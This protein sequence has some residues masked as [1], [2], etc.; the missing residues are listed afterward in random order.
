M[1]ALLE[2]Q[3]LRLTAAGRAIVDGV[4]FQV[5]PGESVAITGPSGAGKTTLAL[6]VLG[7]LR[8]GVTHDGGQVLV[9]GRPTLPQPPP[10]LRGGLVGYVG[11]DPGNSLNPYARVATTLLRVTAR[12]VPRP[13]RSALVSE[14]LA[15][16]G[17][18]TELA[19]RYPHQLS[20]GQQ[21]RVVI[22]AALARNPRLLV[23]D[24][25]TTAL[26]LVAKAEVVAELR[27]VSDAGIS[28]LWVT[29]D[30]ASVETVV[31]RVV[32]IGEP[33]TASYSHA[34]VATAAREVVLT[35]TGVTAGYGHTSVLR[36]VD[37]EL[38][39]GELLAVLGASGVGKSTLARVLT[40]L[41]RPASG[42]LAHRGERLPWDVRR[43]SRAE[44]AAIQLVGQNP[45]EALHPRQTVRTALTRPLVR[46]RNLPTAEHDGE[47]K[48]LLDAVQLPIEVADRLPGELSGGMR[49]R[50]ALARALAAR[51]EVIVCDEITSALDSS[52]QSAILRMLDELRAEL[53]LAVV[54][55][56]H[57]ADV[58]ASVSDRLLVLAS[59]RVART[60]ATADLLPPGESPE[61]R[62]RHLL[63][64]HTDL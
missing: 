31:D 19:Q 23:L 40:G 12:S 17:L 21:Q 51:P 9:D 47:I 25:P 35:A 20:G 62:V 45:A 38:R 50:V 22:A 11:Q 14:L 2:V 26:D 1:T 36:A 13:Q 6:T 41:H 24:E 56:T 15:R 55:I 46:L 3:N 57:D 16:V 60:G 48:L 53:G 42:T 10:E 37:L 44:R 54:L 32:T 4:S 61:E 33:T 27:R 28:L 34:P 49:Q 18:P 52:T 58:A 8:D 7:H 29:H 59:G 43:R 5:E 39:S 64:D 63:I 30:L